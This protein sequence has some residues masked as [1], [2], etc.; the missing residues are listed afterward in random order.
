VDHGQVE[1]ETSAAPPSAPASVAE[2]PCPPPAGGNSVI[3]WV[4]FVVVD[5]RMYAT[6]YDSSKQTLDEGQVGDV[7]ATVTCRIADVGDPDFEPREGD[8]AYLPASTEVHQ[9][10]GRPPGEALAAREE[11]RW[12]LFE[13]VSP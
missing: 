2:P 9:V 12:R 3:D 4:P 6:G 1:V 8:A 10:R 5:G 11:G 13:P 7:V